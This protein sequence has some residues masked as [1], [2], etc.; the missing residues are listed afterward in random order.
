MFA[1]QANADILDD[2]LE[3]AQTVRD[4]AIQARDRAAAARDRATAARDNAEEVL[5]RIQ[6]AEERLTDEMRDFADEAIE[7]LQ[8]MLQESM[9][10]RAEFVA[11]GGCSLAVCEPFRQDLVTLF[12]RMEAIVNALYDIAGLTGTRADFQRF[13]DVIQDLPGRGLFP[14]Y[15]VL[16]GSNNVFATGLLDRLS[17]A[18]EGLEVVRDAMDHERA[19]SSTGRAAGDNDKLCD[20]DITEDPNCDTHLGC[21]YKSCEFWYRESPIAWD[22]NAG[23]VDGVAVLMKSLAAGIQGL[24]T[25]VN[26]YEMD[27]GTVAINGK[28]SSD[29]VDINSDLCEA[30]AEPAFWAA[31]F[32]RSRARYCSTIKMQ[33]DVRNAIDPPLPHD[34]EPLPED[35]DARALIL[36]QLKTIQANESIIH[37]A[38]SRLKGG[39]LDNDGD[40]DLADYAKMQ[41][42][43]TGP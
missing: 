18:L 22:E 12:E 10:G 3:L 36:Q 7:D 1:S 11:D 4:R 26:D 15:R 13:I 8:R 19:E 30:V 9:E 23:I 2:I 29:P 35:D 31:N 17:E 14:L 28:F 24:G 6:E 38:V 25:F 21:E 37:A 16:G 43:F 40:V 32:M 41:K 42:G 20:C 33:R 34:A 39:D 27:G 5:D